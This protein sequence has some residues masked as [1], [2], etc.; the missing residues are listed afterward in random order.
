MKHISVHKNSNTDK[1]TLFQLPGEQTS[2]SEEPGHD[3][4]PK[5]QYSR[6][7]WGEEA[8]DCNE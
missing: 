8:G 2:S 7:K 5:R 1:L 3:G 4:C 6:K